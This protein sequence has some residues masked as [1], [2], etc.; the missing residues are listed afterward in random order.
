MTTEEEYLVFLRILQKVH[1]PFMVGGSQLLVLF[2]TAVDS[3]EDGRPFTF[4]AEK[5]WLAVHELAH[6]TIVALESPIQV[7]KWLLR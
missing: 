5:R 4:S 1:W 3:L 7:P 6:Q 2:Q